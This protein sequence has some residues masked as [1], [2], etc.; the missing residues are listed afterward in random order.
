M[1]NRKYIVERILKT[2]KDEINNPSGV[3]S[4]VEQSGDDVLAVTDV[5][6]CIYLIEISTNTNPTSTQGG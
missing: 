1:G 4:E 3:F 2:L 5:D 6:G